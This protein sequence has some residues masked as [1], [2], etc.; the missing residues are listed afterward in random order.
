[1]LISQ[2]QPS[3]TPEARDARIQGTVELLCVVQENG[4]VQE[5]SV[6][7]SL[8]Y[9][10]DEAAIEAVGKWRFSPGKKDGKPVRTYVG[11]L[12]NFALR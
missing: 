5:C 12:L 2:V 6:R 4:T 3:Y 7:K 1:V 10:L 9:G 8:G 11:L